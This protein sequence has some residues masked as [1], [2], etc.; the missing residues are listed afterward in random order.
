M[1]G[2]APVRTATWPWAS[3]LALALVAS[4]AVLLGVALSPAQAAQLPIAPAKVTAVVLT[5]RCTPTV[6]TANGPV[7]GSQATTVTVAGLGTGCGG[8]V[9]ALTLFGTGG[10]ALTTATVTLAVNQGASVTI[11][12]PAYAPGSVAGAAVTVGSWGV[13]VAWTYTPPVVL[14]LVSCAVLNDPGGD[15]TCAA[16]LTSID[17][18]GGPPSNQYNAYF[19]VTSSSATKSVEWQITLNLADP[20]MKLLATRMNSNNA[21]ML[22]PGWTCSS[23]PMLVLRGQAGPNTQYVGGGSEV[24]VWLHGTSDASQSNGS[25]FACP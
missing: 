15:K 22:A 14:P 10:A 12:V 7:T 19:K 17:A 13:P 8:R 23:M 18:W 2:V 3:T 24:N 9:L 16:T 1:S 20:A 25:L 4:L 11:T 6:T 21:V 5:G